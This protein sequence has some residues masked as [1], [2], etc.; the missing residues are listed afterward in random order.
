[1]KRQKWN[2]DWYFQ[3]G[4]DNPLMADITKENTQGSLIQLPHDAMIHEERDEHT[5]N[6]SQSG[7]YPGGMYTYTKRFD[8]P[9]DW[10]NHTVFFEFEGIYTNARIFINGDFVKSCHNG[11]DNFYVKADMFLRYGE[12]NEIKVDV[13][14]SATPNSRWYSG[15]GMYRDVNILLGDRLHMVKDGVT[16]TTPEIDEDYAIIVVDTK[17]ENEYS[18]PKK[19]SLLTEVY[20]EF[21]QLVTKEITKVTVYDEIASVQQRI[22]IEHPKLWNCDTPHLYDCHISL[23]ENDSV[24]DEENVSFGIRELKLDAK[25]GLRINGKCVKLRGSCIHHDNGVIGAA[26]FYDAEKRRC[27]IMKEAGFNCIR[28]SHHP[29]SKAMLKACDELGML[30]IDELSDV[31]N[32]CKNHHDYA[33]YFAEHWQQD[34]RH[35]VEKNRNHPSVIMYCMGNEIA[36]AGTSRGAHWNRNI[37]QLIKQ[38]DPSRYTLNAINGLNAAADKMPLIFQDLQKLAAPE[39]QEEKKQTLDTEE[40]HTDGSNETNAM[41]SM[42]VG[43]M[44]DAM[45]AHPIMSETLEEISGSMDVLGFNYMSGRHVLE[46]TLHPNH[47]VLGS[48]TFPSEIAQLWS[49]VE[50]YPHIIGDMTWTGY[51]YLGE[52][53]I[54]NF[55]YDGSRPF[56]NH[57]P[58]RIAYCGDI[59]ITGYRRTISYYREIV[60]GLR[61][62]PYI[63]VERIEHF[64]KPCL[65]T[66]WAWSDT[67]A[68]WTW[69]G[70]EDKPVH[71]EVYSDADE[72]ELFLNDVSLGKQ[73]A[74]K[75]HACMATFTT[76]YQP[77]ILTAINYRNGKQCE[78]ITLK[79]AQPSVQVQMD[80]DRTILYNDGESL[81]FVE[82]TLVD[83]FG[84]LNM[85][86]V[87]EI[88]VTI[89]GDGCVLQG[90][91]SADPQSVTSYQDTTWKTWD[92]R[93]FVV[94]RSTQISGSTTLHIA[95]DGKVQDICIQ[96][97]EKE[98]TNDITK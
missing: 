62:Q 54:G 63:A 58:D 67:I 52:A 33:Q 66:P 73:C 37:H 80:M 98:Q 93:L 84:A 43:P 51:D 44:A 79:T 69:H 34:V 31:W 4:T 81:A 85:Q 75:K 29:M 45:A 1:M 90:M 50:Q 20:D 8:V 48:E 88:H 12:I 87:K 14:N 78:E 60:Y 15:S 35:M 64:N 65:K 94:L 10:E 16:I 74:G 28:S 59:D 46:K 89:D 40:V 2:A 92:G 19:V 41:M 11:Y 68:S 57:W 9:K 39:Q 82:L 49:K 3:K 96:T 47:V 56:A 55:Y 70:F 5:A 17:I 91:G 26:T 13:N 86:E 30:V 36:E 7:F 42:L 21:H 61:Q 76:T 53:G 22:A 6:G 27:K 72:V 83:E 18:I 25:H 23:M 32:R 97:I 24:L 38:L 77:G 95:M 71:I